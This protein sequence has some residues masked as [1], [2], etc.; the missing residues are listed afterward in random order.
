M[1]LDGES[2]GESCRQSMHGILFNF[3]YGFPV[4]VT[5]GHYPPHLCGPLFS[6]PLS[7]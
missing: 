2:D 6:L 4:P 5:L 3:M 7:K 1:H